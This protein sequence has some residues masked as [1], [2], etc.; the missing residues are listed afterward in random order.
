MKKI[1]IL[2]AFLCLVSV[3]NS[4]DLVKSLQDSIIKL[5]ADNDNLNKKNK[6]LE[7]KVDK[8]S[9]KKLKIQRDSLQ[10]QVKEL[11]VK[12][13]EL[14]LNISKKEEECK[15]NAEKIKRLEK[16]Q[17]QQIDELDKVYDKIAK[18]YNMP[19]DQLIEVFIEKSMQRDL[20]L[21][22]EKNDAASKK[23][24]ELQNYF[25]AEQILAG[26]YDAKKV[27]NAQT[28]IS[29]IEQS[30][31]VKNLYDKLRIYNLYNAG[32]KTTIGDILEIDKNEKILTDDYAEKMKKQDIL[33][34]IAEYC[35]N[36]YDFIEYPYLYGIIMEIIRIKSKDAYADIKHL[37]DKL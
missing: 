14:E 1:V 5:N 3:A 25:A 29:K 30:E 15:I 19:F 17:K 24:Q 10:K 35:R 8:L 16:E 13:S 23:L 11:R 9:G 12:N 22:A 34:Q 2:I 7:K 4:Q 6:K 37:L 28:Q 33:F 26:A 18:T 21:L 32:L 20:L 31:K 36:Y 27:E